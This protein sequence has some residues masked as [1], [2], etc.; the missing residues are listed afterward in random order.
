MAKYVALRNTINPAIATVFGPENQDLL[1]QAFETICRNIP[2]KVEELNPVA[3]FNGF[4][5]LDGR[6]FGLHQ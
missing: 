5:R 4:N 3:S 6:H 1:M 2:N